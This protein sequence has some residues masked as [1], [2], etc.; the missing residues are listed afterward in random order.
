MG[1][2]SFAKLEKCVNKLVAKQE[3]IVV[4]RYN[5]KTKCIDF[6]GSPELKGFASET[7]DK[8]L[9]FLGCMA[10]PQQQSVVP[11]GGSSISGA[12]Q[13]KFDKSTES[14]WYHCQHICI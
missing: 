6:Q 13:H 5:Q 11:I 1:K 9:S 7:A 3:K 10:V 12:R 8:F 4:M 14:C 2:K